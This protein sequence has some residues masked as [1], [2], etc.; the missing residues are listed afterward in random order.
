MRLGDQRDPEGVEP[1]GGRERIAG[2]PRVQ[3]RGHQEG[4]AGTVKFQ[5]PGP[6]LPRLVL[7]DADGEHRVLQRTRVQADAEQHRVDLDQVA[8][9]ELAGQRVGD[10][11][12]RAEEA[13]ERGRAREGDRATGEHEVDHALV[14]RDKQRGEVDGLVGLPRGREAERGVEA[15]AG[16]VLVRHVAVETAVHRDVDA[17]GY[18]PDDVGAAGPQRQRRGRD[19]GGRVP[20][21]GAGD[22][23]VSPAAEQR[24]ELGH[25]RGVRGEP[26]RERQAGRG[27]V[28]RRAV[29]RLPRILGRA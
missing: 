10:V 18:R 16:P 3:R 23:P 20:G 15:D 24:G 17:Q 6:H 27:D 12:A 14:E 13:G 26:A 8:A 29:L 22:H 11:V 5:Y 21:D 1:R 28:Q 2:Q 4:E 19:A 9:L 25:H 7:G